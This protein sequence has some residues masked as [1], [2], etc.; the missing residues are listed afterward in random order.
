MIGL[1]SRNIASSWQSTMWRSSIYKLG[2]SGP[3]NHVSGLDINK[4]HLCPNFNVCS[5]R[6]VHSTQ[7]HE[8]HFGSCAR[9]SAPQ[10]SVSPA[11]AIAASGEAKAADV[12]GSE[13]LE[14]GMTSSP[15]AG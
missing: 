14:V 10:S 5:S 15:S 1:P 7:Q 2:L 8:R 9:A 4:L 6:A 13:F 11:S 12:R 3:K